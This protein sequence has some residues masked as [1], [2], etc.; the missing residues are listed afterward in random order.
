M[1]SYYLP[2]CK[3]TAKINDFKYLYLPYKVAALALDKGFHVYIIQFKNL[4]AT[5]HTL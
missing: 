2:P 3:P 5:L 4:V 1:A